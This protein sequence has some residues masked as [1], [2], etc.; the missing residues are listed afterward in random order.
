M[1]RLAAKKPFNTLSMVD[2][3][4]A[5]PFWYSMAKSKAATITPTPNSTQPK[6]K[7]N[8]TVDSIQERSKIS[9]PMSPI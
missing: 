5:L 3:M 4:V 9:A 1:T 8:R 7:N 2:F 6:R